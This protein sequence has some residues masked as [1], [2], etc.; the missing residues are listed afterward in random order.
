[1]C[2]RAN[3]Y[4]STGGAMCTGPISTIRGKQKLLN[5]KYKRLVFP[6]LVIV[7]LSSACHNIEECL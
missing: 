4:N 2:Y 6:H 3:Q 7:N 5:T 1:M